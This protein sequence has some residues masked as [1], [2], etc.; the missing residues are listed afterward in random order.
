MVQYFCDLCEK[1]MKSNEARYGL[2]IVD[3]DKEK[4]A[5][6]PL[7]ICPFCKGKIEEQL[8]EWRKHV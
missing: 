1:E 4:P 7:E 5:M 2:S 8:N 3:I 6:A